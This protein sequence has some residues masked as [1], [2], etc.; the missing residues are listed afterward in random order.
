MKLLAWLPL[1]LIVL[2]TAC[3]NSGASFMVDGDKNHSIS[4]LREQRWL[5]SNQVEQMLVPARFPTCQRR[6][7][8]DPDSKTFTE[9]KLYQNDTRLFVVQQGTQW[10]AVGTEN[11]QVQKFKAPPVDP[12]DLIGSFQRKDGNLV[13]VPV[14]AK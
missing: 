11:C 2:L 4:L 7:P 12:G 1:S 6:F 3:E 8:I 9:M 5:W 10:W 13:F 14:A